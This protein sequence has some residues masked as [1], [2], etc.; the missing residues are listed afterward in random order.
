MVIFLDYLENIVR[1][2][3]VTQHTINVTLSWLKRCISAQS[4]RPFLLRKPRTVWLLSNPQ[5]FWQCK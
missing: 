3:M 5:N 2:E 4:I 1:L